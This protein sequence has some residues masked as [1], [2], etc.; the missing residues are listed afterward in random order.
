MTGGLEAVMTP[1]T[2][3]APL[4]GSMRKTEVMSKADKVLPLNRSSK[5]LTS[6]QMLECFVLLSPLGGDSL[7]DMERL[8][9]DKALAQMLGYAM[10]APDTARQWLDRF[11]QEEAMKARPLQGFF[12]PP[13]SG[14]LAGTTLGKQN[15]SIRHHSIG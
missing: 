13:E 11:H 9:R 12:L 4:I 6:E 3:V 10:P 2:G 1:W 8:S 7:E 15:Q 14:P 5:G